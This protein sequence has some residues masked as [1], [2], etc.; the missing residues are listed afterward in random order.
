MIR[1]THR[2]ITPA[3][4]WRLHDEVLVEQVPGGLRLWGRWDCRFGCWNEDGQPV[5]PAGPLLG[6]LGV[7]IEPRGIRDDA[8]YA[9]RAALTAYWSIVPTPLRLLAVAAGP[10]QWAWLMD[11][12]QPS[13]SGLARRD[14][15]AAPSIRPN[16]TQTHVILHR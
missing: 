9:S 4:I 5:T 2:P 1:Q 6:R 7:F 12:W 13:A 16:L 8:W 11:A 3:A 14:H 10:H 15:P